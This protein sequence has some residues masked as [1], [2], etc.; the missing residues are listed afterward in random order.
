MASRAHGELTAFFPAVRQSLA[1]PKMPT[2]FCFLS[3]RIP[4]TR[5]HVIRQR[6]YAAS[7]ADNSDGYDMMLFAALRPIASSSVDYAIVCLS[8]CLF[9]FAWFTISSAQAC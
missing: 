8:R 1:T 7:G 3:A 2:F 6:L 5:H 9:S 4:H